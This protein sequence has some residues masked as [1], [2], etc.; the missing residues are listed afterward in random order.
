MMSDVRLS[1][2]T[3]R[4]GSVQ[5]GAWMVFAGVDSSGGSSRRFAARA[6]SVA[7]SS[8]VRNCRSPM[9][10]GRSSGVIVR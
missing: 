1:S 4:P 8:S 5:Y 3:R 10:C 2:S 9:F 6:S 7:A